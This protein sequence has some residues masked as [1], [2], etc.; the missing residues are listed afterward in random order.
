LSIETLVMQGGA[1]EDLVHLKKVGKACDACRKDRKMLGCQVGCV[2]V[3]LFLRNLDWGSM[4]QS[5]G[6]FC[7]NLI[8]AVC[9]AVSC[10]AFTMAAAMKTLLAKER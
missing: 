10:Q 5:V 9:S 6:V 3:N 1:K 7:F 8:P 4:C 2:G